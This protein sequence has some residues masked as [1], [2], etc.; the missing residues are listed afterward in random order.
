MTGARPRQQV[1]YAAA[2]IWNVAESHLDTWDGKPQLYWFCGLLREVSELGLAL[3][4]KH[5]HPGPHPDTV[6]D[7]LAQ[8]GSI[9]MNWLREKEER[10]HIN[11]L[12]PQMT[13]L[14]RFVLLAILYL[15][16]FVSRLESLRKPRAGGYDE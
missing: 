13:A 10:P 15:I 12:Q 11:S 8:I 16:A 1:D 7:E 2:M 5:R 3:L 6:G 9:S 4:G 14:S